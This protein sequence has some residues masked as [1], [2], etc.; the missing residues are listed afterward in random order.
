MPLVIVSFLNIHCFNFLRQGHCM[1]PGSW[2]RMV[3]AKTGESVE[4]KV[5]KIVLEKQKQ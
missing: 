2:T 1:I 5:A 3:C 4:R